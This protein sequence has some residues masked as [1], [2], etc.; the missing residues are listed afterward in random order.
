MGCGAFVPGIRL[1]WR[2]TVLVSCRTAQSCRRMMYVCGGGI[3][4]RWMVLWSSVHGEMKV[5]VSM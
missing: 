4:Q 5:E 3:Y 1:V 2:A